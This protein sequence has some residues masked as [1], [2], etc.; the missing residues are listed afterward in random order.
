MNEIDF[1]L[2]WVDGS[3]T[4]WIRERNHYLGIKEENVETSRFRDWENLQYWFRGVEKFAPWVHRIYFVTWGHVPKWLNTAHPKLT[5]V[6]HEDYIPAEYLPTFSSHPIEL[7]LHRIKGLS[8]RFVYFNDDTFLI[9][10]VQPEDFFKNGLP[11]DCCIET[12]LVQDDIHNPFASILMNDAALVNMHYSKKEV[13]KKHWKLWFHP[14]CGTMVLRNLLMLPYREFSSF[15]YS[16]IASSFLKETFERV[17]QEEGEILDRVCRTR[18][19]SASD[20][21][22]YVMK[23]WQYMEGK[24]VPQ[25][26]K[27]GRFYTVG[28]HDE[29]IHDTL[30]RQQCKMICINDTDNV[31]DFEKQKKRI[32]ESFERILPEKSSFEKGL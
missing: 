11:R 13:I 15:K 4:D 22:Q 2:P 6:R 9:R 12:A 16:H 19:R 17:W 31:G 29:Q 25:S 32:I 1:V 23:Y 30:R 5:V 21:N 14:A 20:V 27:T 18:F 28:I 10:Q 24:Y 8:D 3:D 26:P 7:N